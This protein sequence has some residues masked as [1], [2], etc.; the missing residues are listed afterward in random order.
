[1]LLIGPVRVLRELA[2]PAVIAIIGIGT[3]NPANLWWV[4][5]GAVIPVALGMVPWLTTRYRVGET[6]FERRSGLLNRTKVTAPLDRV[7]TVD[8]EAPVLHRVLGLVKVSV[9]T[10]VDDT[11]IDLDG[12]A[13]AE[14]E[15]L[16]GFLLARARLMPAVPAAVEPGPAEPESVLAA[17][18]WSWL[19][20]APFQLSRLAI[21]AGVLGALS[22]FGDD[23]PFLALER[24]DDAWQWLLGFALPL[25]IG[26]AAAVLLVAWLLVALLGYVVQWWGMRLTRRDGT[27]RL[28]AGLL[29]T[30]SRTMEEER[31]RGVELVEP[32]LMRPVGGAELTALATGLGSDDIAH[33]LPPC[34][35]AVAVSVGHDVLSVRD[36]GDGGPLTV[37][38]TQHGPL[39]RRRCHVRAQWPTLFLTAASVV[40]VVLLDLPGWLPLGVA[41]AFGILGVGLAEAAYRTLG[42]ARC[43][44]HLVS[45][46]GALARSTTV[47]EIDGVIGWVLRQS[48]FQRR[49]GLATLLA[50]TA[51]G[52]EVV[53][54]R[55]VPVETGLALARA[56][57]PE[58]VD[59]FLLPRNG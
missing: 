31:V 22:Q 23:L 48:W 39:A 5:P 55:D 6:Q 19:R 7:R 12:L 16:R 24:V 17:V 42:H 41:L 54:V 58:L 11:R 4:L 26:V 53:A 14:A 40:P 37:R 13:R 33:L 2:I 32:A 25:L 43:P 10:G 45:R 30:R 15:R 36:P 9:G 27:L 20:Y 28:V 47:L 34:P 29:T 49:V 51:A 35:R 52:P 50:T 1:M 3:T 8:L 21:A 18:D 56:C 46:T 57:T 59:P 44:A 38:L